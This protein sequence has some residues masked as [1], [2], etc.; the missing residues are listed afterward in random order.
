MNQEIT[1]NPPA[2]LDQVAAF[3][4]HWKG[5]IKAIP[6]AQDAQLTCH[7]GGAGISFSALLFKDG[8]V[9]QLNEPT[10]GELSN[11]IRSYLSP[12]RL[13]TELRQRATELRRQA[14]ELET[15]IMERRGN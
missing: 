15:A 6:G 4:S 2:S 10:P 9:K 14:D 7:Y 1:D 12:S 11:A 5:G 8:Q 13:A 3:L